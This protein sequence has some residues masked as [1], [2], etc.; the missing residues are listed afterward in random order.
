M[1]FARLSALYD[2]VGDLA[3]RA[4]RLQEELRVSQK[5][6][7]GGTKVWHV[8]NTMS[9]IIVLGRHKT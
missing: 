2:G 1:P 6:C 9:S 4:R 3:E 5:V 8:V 7:A